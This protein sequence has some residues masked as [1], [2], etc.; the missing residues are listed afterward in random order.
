[1]GLFDRFKKKKSEEII[2]DRLSQELP[3]KEPDILKRWEE[4]K[5]YEKRIEK[6]TLFFSFTL[7]IYHLLL[8]P[9]NFGAA[10]AEK[11]SFSML[12]RDKIQ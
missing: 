12:S 8:N 11:I 5:I 4:N 6:N 9:P 1:M 2:I 3:Q 10:N 7:Q